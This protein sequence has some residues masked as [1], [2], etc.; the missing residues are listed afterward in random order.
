MLFATL[1]E[2]K[3]KLS[4]IILERNQINDECMKALGE[5]V[6]SNQYLQQLNLGYNDISDRGIEILAPYI[7]G[8]T[9]LEYVNLVENNKITNRSIA[10]L[11]KVIEASH[12]TNIICGNTANMWT[13]FEAP[14]LYNQVK[15]GVVSLDFYQRYVKC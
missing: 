6:H 14:L 9:V 10:P 4:Q 8:N 5:F 13:H 7:E 12:I 2:S 15:R 11:F 3:S 1:K